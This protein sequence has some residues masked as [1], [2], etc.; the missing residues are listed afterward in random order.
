MSSVELEKINFQNVNPEF[1]QNIYRG[2]GETRL[3][4]AHSR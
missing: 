3:R 4:E 2:S 1:S